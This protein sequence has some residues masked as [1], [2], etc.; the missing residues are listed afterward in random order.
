MV[1]FVGDVTFKL[2][3]DCKFFLYAT[4]NITYFV[5]FFVN[6]FNLFDNFYELS[7]IIKKLCRAPFLKRTKNKN[8]IVRSRMT[9]L[10][11]HAYILLSAKSNC[12]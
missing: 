5:L 6:L 8:V 9:K 4:D 1:K 2:S 10:F 7:I 3:F 11:L 12:P